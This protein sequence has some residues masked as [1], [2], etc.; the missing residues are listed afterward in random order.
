MLIWNIRFN[1]APDKGCSGSMVSKTS[2]CEGNTFG[3]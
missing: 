1:E 2:K 3:G